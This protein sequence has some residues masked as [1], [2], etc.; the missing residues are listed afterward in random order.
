MYIGIPM[1]KKALFIR[2]R[3]Q[4]FESLEKV[5]G[6]YA[7]QNS[8]HSNVHLSGKKQ[9]KETFKKELTGWKITFNNEHSK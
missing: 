9:T 1:F 8:W 7:R 5:Q 2:S 4:F 3:P 6:W